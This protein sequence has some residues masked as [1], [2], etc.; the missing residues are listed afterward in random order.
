MKGNIPEGIAFEMT[1]TL[2]GKG[3]DVTLI[4][5]SLA[6]RGYCEYYS[7]N[8]GEAGC[9]GLSAVRN[10]IATGKIGLTQVSYLLDEPPGPA[11][12]IG[13]LISELCARCSYLESGC[14]FISESPPPDATPCGGYRLLQALLDC[15]ALR[16]EIVRSLVAGG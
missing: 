15:G 4:A 12:R 13:G 1:T 3:Q 16:P 14:D 9:G 8:E 7:G 10:G 5:V 6:C 2:T 11:R